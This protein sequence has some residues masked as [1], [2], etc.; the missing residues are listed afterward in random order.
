MKYNEFTNQLNGRSSSHRYEI[1]S[2]LSN[3]T[4]SKICVFLSKIHI[5]NF[6]IISNGGSQ[7]PYSQQHRG[8]YFAYRKPLN[9]FCMFVLEHEWV[10][11]IYASIEIFGLRL[12]NL[13]L[14]SAS[15]AIDT[16]PLCF[17]NFATA[18]SSD[19]DM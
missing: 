4:K 2:I 9:V 17:T 16:R 19:W 8:L 3:N 11:L 12:I 13:W 14:F 6:I 15:S 7:K 10:L 1:K 18:S 5:H